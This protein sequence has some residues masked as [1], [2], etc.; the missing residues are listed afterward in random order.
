MKAR[1]G[2]IDRNNRAK[3]KG[4][5][6]VFHR[7]WFFG[8]PHGDSDWLGR[9]G[10]FAIFTVSPGCVCVCLCGVCVCVREREKERELC[11]GKGRRDPDP[12]SRVIHRSFSDVQ[13]I[14]RAP[15]DSRRT[16]PFVSRS[17]SPCLSSAFSS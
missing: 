11:A 14:S 12:D 8:S 15:G 16:P 13:P 3:S 10:G 6:S 7:G 4:S 2:R 1:E 17:V 5:E 9:L